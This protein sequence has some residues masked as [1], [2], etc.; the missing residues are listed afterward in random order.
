M[1]SRARLTDSVMDFNA[2]EKEAENV[3]AECLGDEP[4]W[5]DMLHVELFEF[6]TN[7]N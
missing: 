7:P 4:E 1:R 3:L 6:E 5:E 2:T